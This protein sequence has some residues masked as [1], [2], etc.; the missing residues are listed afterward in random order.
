LDL[1][2]PDASL[3][4]ALDLQ[5]TGHR[6]VVVGARLVHFHYKVKVFHSSFDAGLDFQAASDHLV[7]IQNYP[8][9][10]DVRFDFH[11]FPFS[12]VDVWR[13]RRR[14]P[15][16]AK[17][18]CEI[19]GNGNIYLTWFNDRQYEQHARDLIHTTAT[20]IHS[21]IAASSSFVGNVG[22]DVAASF[23]FSRASRRS[24]L[25]AFNKVD[26]ITAL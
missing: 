22:P 19:A 1:F 15:I 21:G 9:S 24:R 4:P 14:S 20:A 5:A 11:T 12:I 23:A 17:K 16:Q 25:A 26:L 7:V 18:K 8:P 10:L 3:G 6:L 13:Q 2:K